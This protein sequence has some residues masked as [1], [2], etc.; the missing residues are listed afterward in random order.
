MVLTKR[1][2]ISKNWSLFTVNNG[3]TAAIWQRY[4]KAVQDINIGLEGIPTI[5]IPQEN[6]RT[7][8]AQI[9]HN[10]G[11]LYFS[12]CLLLHLSTYPLLPY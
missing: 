12:T 5:A 1:L 10:L 8:S 2:P 9:K 4:W 7:D 6:Y 11:E 3:A